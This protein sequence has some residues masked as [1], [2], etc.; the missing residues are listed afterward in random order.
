M[1]KL[2]EICTM[3]WLAVLVRCDGMAWK[4]IDGYRGE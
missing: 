4:G 1:Y 2:G 3:K